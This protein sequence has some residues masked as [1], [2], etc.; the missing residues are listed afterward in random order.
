MKPRPKKT[1]RQILIQPIPKNEPLKPGK[2]SRS[3]EGRLYL[4]AFLLDR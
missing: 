2:H 4:V 3:L 1:V